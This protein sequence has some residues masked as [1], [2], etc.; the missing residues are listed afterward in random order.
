MTTPGAGRGAAEPG[1]AIDDFVELG[2]ACTGGAAGVPTLE[3][4]DPGR[5]TE[6]PGRGVP[7]PT[8]ADRGVE[9]LWVG[10]PEPCGLN[11]AV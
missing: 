5:A 1:R 3:T 7:P 6:D 2:I 11:V 9:G 8:A 10:A 4:E